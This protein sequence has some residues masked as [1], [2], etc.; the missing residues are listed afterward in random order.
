MSG[1]LIIGIVAIGI[2]ICSSFAMIVH[3]IVGRKDSKVGEISEGIVF[4]SFA[5]ALVFLS[6]GIAFNITA[7]KDYKKL[8]RDMQYANSLD[9]TVEQEKFEHNYIV[10]QTKW[11]LR[12]M[13][14]SVD[15]YG[16]FSLYYSIKDELDK[17]ELVDER[18]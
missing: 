10:V 18:D 17:G 2:V 12:E 6:I 5:I 1:Y 16:I 4:V 15:K 14:V 11:S 7:E 8:E 9:C 13:K 3:H